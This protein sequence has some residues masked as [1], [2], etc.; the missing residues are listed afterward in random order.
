MTTTE[1]W[2]VDGVNLTD[3]TYDL[4]TFDG[5][6]SSTPAVGNNMA[7]AQTHGQKW[8]PKYFD[9]A[10]KVL[11]MYVSTKDGSGVEGIGIDGK[12]EN[13]DANLDKLMLLFTRRRKL[14][15]V[16]RTLSDGSV[17]QANCE[18][19]SVIAPSTVGLAA[20]MISV[21]LII[22]SGFWSDVSS[23]TLV[24]TAPASN[25]T[26]TG[27]AKSTAPITDA[28]FAITGP[29]TNP[30]VTDVETGSYFQYAGS[31]ASGVTMT[32]T[33][34]TMTVTNGNAD[35]IT[36]IGNVNWLT[37]Y[38]NITSGV[39]LSFSGSG[40]SGATSLAVTG[41]NRFVR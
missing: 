37:L 10:V 34:S 27:A 41:K 7:F 25:V 2:T 14:L 39:V 26:V 6:D 3:L 12:R 35:L 23:S 11:N 17:R 19:V 16:H 31:V 32:V 36:H 15:N 21:E 24:T 30:K 40:T 5:M 1:A 4:T 33:N 38:P 22:P 20:G 28:V 13:F 18:V 8:V 9:Q 29:I